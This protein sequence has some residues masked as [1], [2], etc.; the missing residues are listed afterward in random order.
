VKDTCTEI[1]EGKRVPGTRSAVMSR[2]RCKG[3][4]MPDRA[5]LIGWQPGKCFQHQP[6]RVRAA[7][8][9]QARQRQEQA[10]G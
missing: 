9:A 6:Q 8:Y 4:P 3:T 10:A 7:I 5:E 1:L 2:R